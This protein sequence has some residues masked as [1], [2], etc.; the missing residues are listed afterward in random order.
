MNAK[1]A[2]NFTMGGLSNRDGTSNTITF[3]EQFAA[4]G[5]SGANG[6]NAWIVPVYPIAG[7]TGIGATATTS[8]IVAYPVYSA[9]PTASASGIPALPGTLTAA[10]PTTIFNGS[11][12]NFMGRYYHP[13]PAQ[14]Q[15]SALKIAA[16]GQSIITPLHS[17]TT[18]VAMGDGG[19]KAISS[20]INILTF[21]WLVRPDDGQVI[22]SDF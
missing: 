3:F 15:N 22:G 5:S 13:F 14:T 4:F 20:G 17:G 18:P 7:N 21:S 11:R 19:V 16:A 8:D 12:T 6:S 2:S 9:T 1:L 10:G